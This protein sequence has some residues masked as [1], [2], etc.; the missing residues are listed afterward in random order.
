[1]ENEYNNKRNI[2]SLFFNDYNFDATEIL[3]IIIKNNIEYSTNQNG[4][5]INLSLIKEDIIDKIYNKLLSM[6]NKN[7]KDK[8]YNNKKNKKDKL[9]ED[10]NNNMNNTVK[11]NNQI[12]I[13]E[14]IKLTNYDK[15]LISL[16]KQ[17]III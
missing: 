3:N 16:S 11:K 6:K 4:F 2:I 7:I 17:E 8:N 10:N 13:I 14:N 5:F 9:L 1:M 12:N 15:S